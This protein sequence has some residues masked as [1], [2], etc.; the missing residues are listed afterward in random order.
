VSGYQITV[1]ADTKAAID[2]LRKLSKQIEDINKPK[3]KPI[4]DSNSLASLT[5]GLQTELRRLKE[6]QVTVD[7]NSTSF[8]QLGAQIQDT[9]NRLRGLE[10]KKLLIDADPSSIVALKAK[11][12]DLQQ[13]LERV[14]T[15][16]EEFKQL[17]G[18]IKKTEA[19]LSGVG[20]A[21]RGGA[22]RLVEN[23][24]KVGF[25]LYGIQ[26]AVRLTS[27]AFK[28][29][30]DETIGREIKFRETILKTQTTLASTN[31]VFRNGEEITDPYQKIV[32][33]TGQVEER[34]DSI[35]KR[36]IE[37]A[38]VTSNDV[39]EVFGI[40][41]SQI[42]MI[43]GGLKDAEDLA[44]SFSAALGTFGLPLHQ[45]RQEIGSIMRG[46]ITQDSYL[47]KALQITPKDIEKAKTQAGGV[48]DFIQKK[49]QGAVAGQKISAQSFSGVLSNL[50]D[51]QELFGQEFG[52]GLLDPL[53]NG[54]RAVFNYLNSIRDSLFAIGKEA[55]ASLGK[56]FSNNLSAL[57]GGSDLFKGMGA[58]AAEGA[59]Q[60]VTTIQNAFA[61]LQS[62]AND[63]IAPVRNI[64]EE[65]VKSAV[66]LGSAFA[67]VG[68]GLGSIGIETLKNIVS[69]I[70]NL[71]EV[72]TVA[73]TGIAGI[74]KVF[75]QLLQLPPVQAFV[76][77]RME[78]EIINRLGIATA[79][80]S[81]IGPIRN[82]GAAVAGLGQNLARSAIGMRSFSQAA[83]GIGVAVSTA[84]K[85][86]GAAVASFMKTN[87]ILLLIQ[88]ALT[89]AIDL[90][91]R[92]QRQ[93]EEI[94][95]SRKAD[96]ALQELNTK[97]K[98]LSEGAS[99]AEKAQKA[100]LE[101]LVS[102]EYDAAINNL[103]EINE[104]LRAQEG[105][106]IFEQ[107]GNSVK[108][109]AGELSKLVRQFGP[110]LSILTGGALGGGMAGIISS[111]N[112][113]TGSKARDNKIFGFD[114]RNIT[115][116]FGR[117][118]KDGWYMQELKKQQAEATARAEKFKPAD[119]G[120]FG[121]S[122]DIRLQAEAATANME[123]QK[124]LEED[125]AERRRAFEEE[126]ANF[127]K[128]QEDAVFERRQ[129]L[130]QK[131][132]DIFRAAG[133]LR[134]AQMEQANAKMIEGEQGASRAAMEALNTYIAE[135]EKGEL[136]IEA[137]KQEIAQEMIK[138]E[139][140][141]ADYR[142]EQEKRIAEIRRKAD[143]Y[144]MAISKANAQ[145]ASSSAMS[146]GSSSDTAG[147]TAVSGTQAAFDTGLRTGP[148]HTIGGSSDYHQDMAFGTMVSLKEQVA[149][150]RQMAQAYDKI[151]R[152]MELSNNGVAGKIFPVNGSEAEQTQWVTSARAAH[153]A[154]NGGTGRDAIDFY[155]P[156]KGTDRYHRSVEDTPMLAPVIPGA[157]KQYFS[158]GPAGAGVRLVKNGQ[159][160]FSLI[161]GRTDRALPQNGV[162][163]ASSVPAQTVAASS[164]RPTQSSAPT[165]SR[166]SSSG[167]T[168]Q[169]RAIL[170]TIR[171][172][173]GTWL[174]GSDKGYQT[175]F[176]GGTFSNYARH[177]D[178]VIRSGG[179][180]SAAAG[181]YQF[182]P[183]TWAATS[184]KLGL[185]DFSPESQ[186]KGAIELL[187]RR[188]VYDA[189]AAGKFTPEIAAKMA[190]EW[191]SF[192]TMAG[193]S[194]YGQPSKKFAELQ[195]FYQQRLGE[196]Q[197]TQPF[198]PVPEY[199]PTLDNP[200]HMQ[201]IGDL[202][203][204]L[205]G[206]NQKLATLRASLTDLSNSKN[207]DAI[208]KA[209][210]DALPGKE[211]FEAMETQLYSTMQTITQ[212]GETAG[213]A[214]DPEAA[215]LMV[216][217]TTNQ[218]VLERE[219]GQTR[220]HIAQLSNLSDAERLKINEMLNK[221]AEKYN[222]DQART[223]EL[224]K[225]QLAAERG[226]AYIQEAKQR[227]GE[228]KE[229]TEIMRNTSQMK[230]SGMRQE[231]IDYKLDV[232]AIRRNYDK[233]FKELLTA[234]P[235]ANKI[236]E[237][238]TSPVAEPVDAGIF[239]APLPKLAVPPAP[240][241]P[242]VAAPAN[243]IV[244]T[245][246]KPPTA[247]T[248]SVPPSTSSISALVAGAKTSLLDTQAAALALST[249]ATNTLAPALSNAFASIAAGAMQ[250]PEGL[251]AISAGFAESTKTFLDASGGL[252]AQLN[253]ETE[254]QI[255]ARGKLRDAII[256]SNDPIRNQIGQW[257]RELA[258]T[259]GMVA[260]LGG[261]I[262]SEL[263]QAMSTSLIGLVNGTNTAKEAFSSM[264]QSIGK[265]MVDTATQML[266]KSLVSGLMGNGAA[267]GGL[268][269]SIFGLSGGGGGLGGLLGGLFGARAAGGHADANR[270]LLIG[271][272]GPEIF[273]PD[274]GGQ[275]VPNHRAQA[276]AAMSRSVDDSAFPKTQ[277]GGTNLRQ[278]EDPFAANKEVLNSI[279]AASQK[280]STEKSIA[281][282][283]GT[284]E[285]KYSRVNSGDLPFITE[286]DA[287]RIAK[288]AE[289][290][291]AKM[292]QQRTLAALRNNPST[293][294]GIGI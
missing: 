208:G 73:V 41:S 183:D 96:A 76:Q 167:I 290:N 205:V 72:A 10:Q 128:S 292:G 165:A 56:L 42:G 226:L 267:G 75:G 150:V 54:L 125:M 124:Q 88:V 34:V 46:D 13:Q 20:N 164:T 37:L 25:A 162:L 248:T 280:R 283:G 92:F 31:K 177:P 258:D 174:G 235:V 77:L 240:V 89:V 118:S 85:S 138:M 222:Q 63:F 230:F 219:L 176:G 160:L 212:L 223:L 185:K 250:L 59:K 172:A 148:A 217:H 231:D 294:R 26:E 244:P 30:F 68:K 201:K 204:Q 193:G 21:G 14:S 48:V 123:K 36:S 8:K 94:A 28:G 293:R 278:Q 196:N 175:M 152:H 147:I 285:I 166:P 274:T 198:R 111:A 22:M 38:G 214:F 114:T 268:L 188:G 51:L 144:S 19:A 6:Q 263:S 153:R 187:K 102:N 178:K 192:P 66:V 119:K 158:G 210:E 145:I 133:E 197:K 256:E 67:E 40:V 86:M 136:D 116:P 287:L 97:Y 11:L 110:L 239:T 9:Q 163:P 169:L 135:R 95:R 33:L 159:K 129:S 266:S 270:P 52:K 289:M 12:G 23:F 80:Q 275:I 247:A 5:R 233:Q 81:S 234:N 154:R 1:T 225:Q 90:F 277:K 186:D 130:A 181:A 109:F 139:K 106:N 78:M 262:Q 224:K 108:W 140:T 261:T 182:M 45:A 241:V 143:E 203:R 284:S 7:I 122:N 71:S 286:D 103:N 93:Q 199:G 249:T 3:I 131:E 245:N 149:L 24:A 253:A 242:A 279:A 220:A 251:Q 64:L 255:E 91:G 264:L 228:M 17:T 35:R 47:A 126:L 49:L 227:T 4:V 134:I 236:S 74:I 209:F 69:L 281:S 61:S 32:A 146:A 237:T 104:K 194:Y 221:T 180:A 216:E 117:H 252:S 137:Q 232:A 190:P 62:H 259:E 132:I 200:Q 195:K 218:M 184:K 291:G 65:L 87:G 112:S 58:S 55:G 2:E 18:E 157:E 168:P 161:H 98:D 260:S 206:S 99:E 107:L 173:E 238:F 257:R 39:V 141:L 84:V 171:H 288:Q 16:S 191:A 276:Y 53:L 121:E 215:K 213:E 43:G 44:I 155:T 113:K 282:I 211:D 120:G 101:S 142:L 271:E 202:E 273:V 272:R 27:A 254:K 179:Y 79:I 151:G 246:G 60:L 115:D 170:D 105:P 100:Y 29:F 156:L 229:Q 269:G 127:R 207:F 50:K 70:S 265:T 15:K 82:M 83:A 57:I 189:L 243:N